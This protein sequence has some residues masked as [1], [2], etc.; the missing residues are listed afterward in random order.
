MSYFAMACWLLLEPG[1]CIMLILG[2]QYSQILLQFVHLMNARFNRYRR[3]RVRNLL[4][5]AGSGPRFYPGSG[6]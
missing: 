6:E 4:A 3:L 2:Q 5:T 1:L